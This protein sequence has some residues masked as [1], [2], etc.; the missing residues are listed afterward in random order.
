M[1]PETGEDP[2]RYAT[3]EGAERLQFR[4]TAGMSMPERLAAVDR[5]LAFARGIKAAGKPA[6]AEDTPGYGSAGE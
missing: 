4:Q 1:K 2:W 6:V 3:F 5:M